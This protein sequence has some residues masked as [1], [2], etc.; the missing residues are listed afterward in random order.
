MTLLVVI[1]VGILVY[2]GHFWSV[3]RY[4]PAHGLAA[5]IQ[6]SDLMETSTWN[7]TV[8][9]FVLLVYGLRVLTLWCVAQM[10]LLVSSCAK[11]VQTAALLGIVLL[12]LPAALATIGL[13]AAQWISPLQAL[14]TIELLQS[15]QFQGLKVFWP[16]LILFGLGLAS[17]LLS[18]RRWTQEFNDRI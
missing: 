6:A 17:A 9:Q 5:P 15:A 8:G 12:V 4:Y 14:S 18:A 16:Y 11:K 7:L 13:E 10:L 2:G 1:L 3:V